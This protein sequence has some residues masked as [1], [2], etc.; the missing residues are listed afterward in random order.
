[1]NVEIYKL[2]NYTEAFCT[3]SSK[4]VVL[5]LLFGL[6]S[7]KS[8]KSDL[9][10]DQQKYSTT[11]CPED[12]SCSFDFVENQSF[13][14]IQDEIGQYY[15]KIKGGNSILCTFKYSRTQIPNTADGQY[16]EIIMFQLD[17]NNIEVDLKDEELTQVKLSYGRICFCKGE[18]GYY[19][20]NSGQLRIKKI[21]DK[22]YQLDLSFENQKV[23][24]I[25]SRI[26]ER[27]DL[28]TQN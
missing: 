9:N 1:M 22:T 5:V 27:M 19:E 16:E 26:Q 11:V 25:I 20:V 13:E 28:N 17:K 7:C 3:L 10:I 14:L 18:T 6:L 2:I 15:P 8:G 21:K 23:P 24:Q 12:G 4:I